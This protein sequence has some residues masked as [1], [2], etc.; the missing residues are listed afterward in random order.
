MQAQVGGERLL[1]IAVRL[2]RCRAAGS[3]RVPVAPLAQAHEPVQGWARRTARALRHR[4]AARRPPDLGAQTVRKG[5]LAQHALRAPVPPQRPGLSPRA[6]TLAIAR[7]RRGPPGGELSSDPVRGQAGV[8]WLSPGR[9]LGATPGPVLGLVHHLGPHR[10]E[11]DVAA[12]GQQMT[13]V[14]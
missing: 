13:G 9:G 11:D 12:G 10:V 8:R 7:L 6:D 14:I 5:G 4:R 2:D 1:G 3:P